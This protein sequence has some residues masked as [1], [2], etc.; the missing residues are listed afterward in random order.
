MEGEARRMN[1]LKAP[2]P[3]RG[4]EPTGGGTSPL[5]VTGSLRMASPRADGPV[6]NIALRLARVV[7]NGFFYTLVSPTSS[8]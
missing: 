8:P 2:C 1:A 3:D 5:G 7:G 6:K 4:M